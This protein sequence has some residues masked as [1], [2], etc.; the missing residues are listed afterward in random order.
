MW[1]R[2][3][4]F[5]RKLMWRLFDWMLC[6]CSISLFSS[7]LMMKEVQFASLHWFKLTLVQSSSVPQPVRYVCL[8]SVRIFMSIA[9][10]QLIRLS[11]QCD[12]HLL[13]LVALLLLSAG[14]L[15]RWRRSSS[16]LQRRNKTSVYMEVW[17]ERQS[18]W[19]EQRRTETAHFIFDRIT[20]TSCCEKT[21]SL[22][23]KHLKSNTWEKTLSTFIKLL[24]K[25]F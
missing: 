9:V 22:Q 16:H 19:S 14:V 15:F 20:L 23:C 13:R 2:L 12:L 1:E 17:E 11:H 5:I 8:A 3:L 21:F 10:C 25:Y 7:Y 18:E 24:E 4:H 6:L